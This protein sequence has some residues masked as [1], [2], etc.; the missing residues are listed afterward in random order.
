VVDQVHALLASA[1]IDPTSVTGLGLVTYGPQDWRSGVLLTPQPNP[2]WLDYPVAEQISRQLGLPVLLDN[3]ANAAAIGEYWLGGIDP[4]STFACLYMGTGI[5]G[6]VVSGRE[7]Y[8]GS[9]SNGVEIGHLSIDVMGEPCSCG[10]R[11]CLERIAGPEA[12]VRNA[13]ATPL[14]QRLELRAAGPNPNYSDFL[15]L[16]TRITTAAA[17]NAEARALVEASA[18]YLGL[19]AVN[20]TNL[21]DVDTIVLAGPGFGPAAALYREIIDTEVNSRWF[22]RRAHPVKVVA[23]A[24]G[25]DAAAVGAA[26]LV[27]RHTLVHRWGSTPLAPA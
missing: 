27:L 15:E 8:R 18:R 16:F 3:D 1:R 13:W 6:G 14:G 24:N 9:S 4:A 2:Q 11:G 19:A 25:S 26:A 21:F 5:G 22:A 23:S 20:L 12:V 10:N 7:V 17:T